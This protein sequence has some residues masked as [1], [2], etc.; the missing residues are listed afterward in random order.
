MTKFFSRIILTLTVLSSVPMIA[1]STE[2][3][4]NPPQEE[5]K[6]IYLSYNDILDMSNDVMGKLPKKEW[7]GIAA[8]TRGGLSPAGI[9]SQHMEIKRIEAVN[10]SSYVNNERKELIVGNEPNIPNDGEDWIFIDDLSDSGK[11]IDFLKRKY[12]K[13]YFVVLMVK[14]HGE[15]SPDLYSSTFPQN[16]WIVYPWEPD[17]VSSSK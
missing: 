5:A 1:F 11:T 14:P 10:I 6:K 13:G 15:K 8:I 16:Q 7:E 3:S 4:S 2:I 9:L 17:W 12:P